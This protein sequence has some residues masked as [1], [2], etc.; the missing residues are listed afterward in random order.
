MKKIYSLSLMFILT[1]ALV[2][3]ASA[4]RWPTNASYRVTTMGGATLAIEDETT[5]LTIFNHQNPAGLALNKKENRLDIGLNYL[6]DSVVTESAFLKDANDTTT[7]ELVRPGAEYRGLTY[8]LGD[9]FVVRAGIEGMLVTNQ[10]TQTPAVGDEVKDALNLSGLGGGASV[11]YK[12][13]SGL[14]LGGGISYLGAG[15]KPDDKLGF[16]PYL[17]FGGTSDKTGC[18][19]QPIELGCWCRL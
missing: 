1:L 14:A 12:T 11:G 7:L 6:Y 9:Q 5:A 16:N 13:D 8:W 15:G 2:G 10:M 17:D 19:L 3:S 18:N 4:L